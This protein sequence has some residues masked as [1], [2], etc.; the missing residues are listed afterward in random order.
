M[1]QRLGKTIQIFLPDG[2]PRG[3]KIAEFTSRTVKAILVPRAQL[4]FACGRPELKAVGLY[5]LV[6]ETEDGDLPT[7]YLGEAED[8]VDRIKQQNKSKDWWNAAIVCVSK[9]ADFTKAH[10]KYL[11][12]FC[13]EEAVAAGRSNYPRRF[14][15]SLTFLNR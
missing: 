10:V 8:C 3:V 12:W 14:Q 15:P 1:S 5:F 13:Y 4:D 7:L 2:N 11:E 9:T 6:G